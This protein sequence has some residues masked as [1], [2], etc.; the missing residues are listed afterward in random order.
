MLSQFAAAGIDTARVDLLPLA[1][2]NSDH[3]GTYAHMDISLDPFP[4]AGTTT[5]CESLYMGVPVVTLQ[6]AATIAMP[7]HSWVL[8]DCMVPIYSFIKCRSGVREC[9]IRAQCQVLSRNV[10]WKGNPGPKFCDYA[11]LMY[12]RLV[13]GDAMRTTS[14]SR[15]WRCWACAAAG[16]PPARTSTCAWPC[17]L[18]PTCPAWPPF[19]P[20]S[21]RASWARRSAMGAPSRAASKRSTGA[22]GATVLP[23]LRAAQALLRLL[24]CSRSTCLHAPAV[25]FAAAPQA[26]S[27]CFGTCCPI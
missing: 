10:L 6:G 20:A 16:W 22:S 1:A 11:R 12:I 9:I 13:Q 19:G 4:Y 24:R 18:R 5:T 2:A 15:C 7:L 21:G 8:Q 25:V 27:Q 26:C 3:L 14:A 17:R 23:A